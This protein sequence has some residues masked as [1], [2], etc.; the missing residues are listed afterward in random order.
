L[1]VEKL[2]QKLEKLVQA[3]SE[4]LPKEAVIVPQ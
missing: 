4:Q 3:L 1:E 2:K